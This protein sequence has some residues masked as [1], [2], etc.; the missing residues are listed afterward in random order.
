[1]DLK[2]KAIL[3]T[4]KRAIQKRAIPAIQKKAIN[5]ASGSN[6]KVNKKSIYIMY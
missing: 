3:A 2:K 1:M 5:A 4:Q 6:Q